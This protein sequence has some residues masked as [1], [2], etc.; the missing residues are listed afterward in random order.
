[1]YFTGV[2]PEDVIWVKSLGANEP[3]C[4]KLQGIIKFNMGAPK[5]H[6]KGFNRGLTNL[7]NPKGRVPRACPWVSIYNWR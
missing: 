7:Y 2:G 5:E 1:V 6:Q 4:S 3:P